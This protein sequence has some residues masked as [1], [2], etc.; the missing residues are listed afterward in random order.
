[1][2]GAGVG[3][4]DHRVGDADRRGGDANHDDADHDDA[5]HDEECSTVLE[6]VAGRLGFR[7]F[8]RRHRSL[9]VAYRA[10][11]AV[12]GAAIVITGI[13]LIP[14]PGPGWLIVFAGL[15]VLATEFAWAER[16]L[17]Y[18]RDKLRAW[19]DWV[20]VQSVIVRALIGLVGLG[21]VAGALALYLRFIGAPGW[22]PIIG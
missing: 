11:V 8:L 7:G 19:T 9:D 16:L 12:L 6:E 2:K 4:A 17:N 15:A 3:E 20:L 5:D 18:G 22:V 21:F 13:A 1:V 14:L 10:V